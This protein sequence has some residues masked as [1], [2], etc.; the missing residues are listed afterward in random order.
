MRAPP[1]STSSRSNA[2]RHRTSSCSHAAICGWRPFVRWAWP[3]RGSRRGRAQ[4]AARQRQCRAHVAARKGRGG[5][6]TTA[7][8]RAGRRTSPGAERPAPRRER[9]RRRL[10]STF[11]APEPSG[12]A[13]GLA[14][15]LLYRA[16]TITGVRVDRDERRPLWA[17][18]SAGSGATRGRLQRVFGG[19]PPRPTRANHARPVG[20]ALLGGPGRGC[21]RGYARRAASCRAGAKLC[22]DP[23]RRW[24]RWYSVLE[25]SMAKRI[26]SKRSPSPRRARP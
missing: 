9:P 6:D 13:A 18:T 20:S 15:P 8:R 19:A 14:G 22:A 2:A 23:S 12:T 7:A 17:E 16:C 4:D 21:G 26:R 10:E 24:S 1:A 11:A 3:D 25:R 5:A